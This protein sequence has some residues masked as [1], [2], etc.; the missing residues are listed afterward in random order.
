MQFLK[1][2]VSAERFPYYA[3]L[4]KNK[5]LYTL[6]NI[7]WRKWLQIISKTQVTVERGETTEHQDQ[8][9]LIQ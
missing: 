5:M 7:V 3:L 2:P 8:K 1:T 9:D 6:D 4:F